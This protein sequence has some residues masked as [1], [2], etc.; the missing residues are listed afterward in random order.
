MQAESVVSSVHPVA[1]APKETL[2][3]LSQSPPANP[4]EQVPWVLGLIYEG[5][6]V[7][8][9]VLGEG[10][11]VHRWV[12]GEGVRVHRW[13]LGEGVRVHRWVLGEGVRV[14]RWV[15]GKGVRVDTGGYC[16]VKVCR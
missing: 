14:H 9:W 8:R 5:V 2:L 15:L 11:R 12:L 4:L 3:R 16:S 6:R 10:V 13:V 1:M 7:H